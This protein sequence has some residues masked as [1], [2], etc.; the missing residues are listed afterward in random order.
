MT[1]LL[2]ALLENRLS[3]R[4]PM[5]MPGHKRREALAP[6]LQT[7]GAGLDITEID[8]F[9][10]LHDADSLLC[11]AMNRAASLWG[12]QRAFF[13]INGSTC[14]LLAGIYSLTCP[15][16]EILIARNCHKAVYHACELRGLTVHYLQPSIDPLFGI[17]ASLSPS[18]VD[19]QL[20]AHPGVK[21]CV[22][23]SPSYEGVLSD[24]GTIARICHD[25]GV[26][27][28]VDE[29]HGAHLGLTGDF[30]ASAVSQGADIV[31]RSVHKT[32]PSLTQTALA[33]TTD[34]CAPAF[35]RALGIFET[36]SPSYLLMASI[37]SCVELLTREKATLFAAWRT[38]LDAFRSRMESL[39]VLRLLPDSDTRGQFFALDPSKLVISCADSTI[40]GPA[41]MERL[42]KSNIEC[43]MCSA[44]YVIAMTGLGD[45]DETLGALAEALLEIDASLSPASA[46]PQPL[47]PP[48]PG[49]ACRIADALIAPREAVSRRDAIGRVSAGYLWAYPPGIPLIVPG[50]RISA[51]LVEAFERLEACGIALKSPDVAP[52]GMIFVLV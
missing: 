28:L 16:D 21:L 47:W 50:E 45:T 24:V 12:S 1:T 2:S 3:G 13:L 38:R 15:G 43:E 30:P 4:I 7:L 52:S 37:D 23:T 11:E 41:L 10:D 9:D 19:A 42:R 18:E 44:S 36:S 34:A 14:G 8:G 31:I 6:Y 49:Q 40:T 46:P 5:H 48:L 33:H 25:H 39:R 22:L 20:R 17:H 27:L 29:A 35:A 26:M 32:L 51:E